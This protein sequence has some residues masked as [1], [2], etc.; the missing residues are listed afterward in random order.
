MKN[1]QVTIAEI[2]KTG[3]VSKQA[4]YQHARSG[5]L[6][7]TDGKADAVKLLLEW[8]AKR[9]PS[10]DDRIGPALEALMRDRG[11]KVPPIRNQPATYTE[12]AATDPNG[13]P[14]YF[15]AEMRQFWAR[16][17]DEYEL[18]SDAL[19]ILRT[20][21]E[22]W[23]RAQQARKAI[24]ADGLILNGRRHPGV[25]IEAASQNLF[26]RA[27]RQL[28]LDIVGPGPIGRPPGR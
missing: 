5:K 15:S 16:V 12:S 7:F 25:D 17:V 21:C 23:D 4:L 8:R 10:H 19:L 20:A 6:T 24:Q 2:A 18:E 11:I 13:C 1:K 3:G 26:L 28:G 22:A 9:D 27:M 14:L